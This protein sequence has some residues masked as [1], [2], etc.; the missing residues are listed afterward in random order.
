MEGKERRGIHKGD[1]SE[2][3]VDRWTVCED[4]ERKLQRKDSEV[5]KCVGLGCSRCHK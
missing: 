3:L 2:G 4:G 1:K 5:N